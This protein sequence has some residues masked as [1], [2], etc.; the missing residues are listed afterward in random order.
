MRA[1]TLPDG[2]TQWAGS[3][4]PAGA[5]KGTAWLGR[6]ST[7]GSVTATWP[8]SGDV[9]WYSTVWST[10]GTWIARGNEVLLIGNTGAPE[11]QAQIPVL[12]GYGWPSITMLA[13]HPQA[14]TVVVMGS[15]TGN[16]YQTE[17]I[18]LTQSGAVSW[19]VK[20][21]MVH[22]SG[23]L[24]L[25]AGGDILLFANAYVSDA[26]P[27]YLTKFTS[28]GVPGSPI[29][30]SLTEWPSWIDFHTAKVAASDD[31]VIAARTFKDCVGGGG[32]FSKWQDLGVARL[33]PNG[34]V[35]WQTPI[36]SSQGSDEQVGGIW[37]EGDTVV[38]VS[39]IGDWKVSGWVW[40]RLRLSD[41]KVLF[42]KVRTVSG[43]WGG[44]APVAARS[45]QGAV[46]ALRDP[47]NNA[48]LSPLFRVDAWG[49]PDCSESAGCA[50]KSFAGCDDGNPCTLENCLAGVC[51]HA[52]A[53]DGMACGQ[54]I[55]TSGK[56]K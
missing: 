49:N 8:L 18:R 36:V 52:N 2:S 25:V 39:S 40:T 13:A 14:G 35:Q 15:S 50:G 17:L 22:S 47:N 12:S 1:Q 4:H 21:P 56:C 54:S 45:G 30:L 19:R 20:T 38:I 26:A 6:T 11:L 43:Q 31:V 53:P 34:T 37:T 29:K 33:G 32:C 48:K 46:V 10:Q 7:S 42:S 16:V 41:G 9:G 55:C 3:W 28:M 23:F 27:M 5:S 44:Y 24:S 51:L